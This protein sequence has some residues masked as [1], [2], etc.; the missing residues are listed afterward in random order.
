MK[1]RPT[2]AADLLEALSFE[3]TPEDLKAREWFDLVRNIV[4]RFVDPR[5]GIVAT[6]HHP[7]RD[8]GELGDRAPDGRRWTE[9]MASPEWKPEIKTDLR[10]ERGATRG[11]IQ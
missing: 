10:K 3:L 6:I 4:I 8:E 11:A 1:K 7:E 2:L 9:F 5:E